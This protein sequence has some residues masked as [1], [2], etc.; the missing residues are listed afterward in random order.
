MSK[1]FIIS[2]IGDGVQKCTEIVYYDKP[3]TSL[4]KLILDIRELSEE[5]TII[6]MG[7]YEFRN[8]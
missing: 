7:I 4:E 1:K 5:K 6:I 8:D 2:Y 3:F